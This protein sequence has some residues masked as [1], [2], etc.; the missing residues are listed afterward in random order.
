MKMREEERNGNWFAVES[1]SFEL[2]MEGIGRKAK[3]SITERS[4]GIVS[5]IRFGVEGMN[6][7]LLGVVESC[8]DFDPA[9]RPFEWREKG[10]FFRLECKENIAGR[11]LLCS[12]I[13]D[14]GKKHRLVFPEGKGF[15]NGW[16]ILAEK[17][18]G[19]GIE[20][21]RENRPMRILKA[22]QPKGDVKKWT[23]ESKNVGTW[24]GQH[25]RKV[26]DVVSSCMESAVW[27]DVGDCV[28]GRELG[29]LQCCLIGKW[30]IKPDP[31]P[32]AKV[33]E[34]WFKD[35]W[36]LNVGVKLAAL[37]EDLLT[38]EFDSP[39]K[40]KWVLESGR[41]SFKGGVLQLEWWR[42]EAGCLRC[43]DSVQEVWIRVVGL[44][45][46]LWKAETLRKLGDACGGFVALDKNTEEKTEVKWARMLIKVIGKSRPSVVNIL[47]GP[48]AFEVQIWWEFSPWVTGVYPISSKDEVK[49]PEEEDDVETRAA[50]RV[51]HPGPKN[52]FAGQWVQACRGKVEKTMGPAVSAPVPSASDALMFGR[53]GAYSKDCWNKK[54]GICVL[55]VG[56]ILQ[57]GT[58]VGS[59][60]RACLPPGLKEPVLSGPRASIRRSPYGLKK[61]SG[62]EEGLKRQQV[63]AHNFP[64]NGPAVLGGSFGPEMAGRQ[65]GPSKQIRDLKAA[66]TG[67]WGLKQAF[68][69]ARSGPSG[70][71]TGHKEIWRR[72]E[73][74]ASPGVEGSPDLLADPAWIC[75]REPLLL[76]SEVSP[77]TGGSPRFESCW[78]NGL[79]MVQ[80]ACPAVGCSGQ[81]NASVGCLDGSSSALVE[82][83]PKNPEVDD[84][85]ELRLHA[86][87]PRFDPLSSTDCSP[88]LFSVFGRPLLTGGSSGLGDYLEN[89]TLGDMEPL[90]VVSADG[91][92]WGKEIE[93]E[94][95]VESQVSVEEEPSKNRPELMGYNN[96]EESC[97]FKFSEFLGVTTVG[98]EEEILKLMRKME[99][100]Q[101]VNKRKGYPTE[102]RCERELRKLECTINYSGKGQNRGG[103][104]RGNFLLKLK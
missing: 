32:V 98:F 50:K 53:G 97:L 33:M 65:A 57:A 10:R 75:A 89:E 52:I 7:L 6:K 44:P 63:G 12:V 99:A 95:T 11:F 41:R 64:S 78:E 23:V 34:A 85:K 14:E 83:V 96:W 19:M 73:G 43:K 21:F 76:A 72:E 70:E 15:L 102:T 62:L 60:G 94:L 26:E 31:W 16:T 38:L 35:A 49:K 40:A 48:R 68:K 91:S 20:T 45:L 103:R 86:I 58:G 59:M 61:G 66:K 74:G 67:Y 3:Y 36:R 47:E 92:E 51:S 13:D 24:G 29:S 82:M 100:Q 25:D 90:R 87:G 93:S 5:W 30:K 101:E 84:D 17:I 69:G 4:R 9:R 28:Y 39:E 81:G 22:E 1:K 79:W 18:R 2:K 42:P 80:S 37:N 46:H 88:P 8:R 104:D 55:G 77:G 54:E 71:V 56:P 27:M